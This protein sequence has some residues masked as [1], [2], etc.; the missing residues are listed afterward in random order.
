VG[1]LQHAD[2]PVRTLTKVGFI[3]SGI[4]I[5]IML[6][7]TILLILPGGDLGLFGLLALTFP[8]GVL[9]SI[10]AMVINAASFFREQHHKAKVATGVLILLHAGACVLAVFLFWWASTSGSHLLG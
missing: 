3:L 2:V 10:A 1:S 4:A 8:P 6:P 5:A 7:G 9:F